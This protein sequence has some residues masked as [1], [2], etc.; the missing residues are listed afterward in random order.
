MSGKYVR[1]KYEG[2]VNETLLNEKDR[3]IEEMAKDLTIEGYWCDETKE[4]IIEWYTAKARGVKPL[5]PCDYCPKATP[6]PDA[7][8]KTWLDGVEVK[9]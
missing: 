9:L 8:P 4:R 7:E 6:S 1:G 2:W 3:I 5:P